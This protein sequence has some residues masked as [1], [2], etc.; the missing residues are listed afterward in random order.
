MD[1]CP[2]LWYRRVA[3]TPWNEY[4]VRRTAGPNWPR[5]RT[6]P[7]QSKGAP[8]VHYYTPNDK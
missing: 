5:R 8:A 3:R 7:Q 4:S 1:R 2:Y 6:I